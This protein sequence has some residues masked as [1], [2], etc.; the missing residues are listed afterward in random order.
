MCIIRKGKRIELPSAKNTPSILYVLCW[1]LGM[2][3]DLADEA[4]SLF[5]YISDSIDL[6]GVPSIALA[7]KLRFITPEFGSTDTA[8]FVMTT[9]GRVFSFLS[10]LSSGKAHLDYPCRRG[11]SASRKPSPSRL[12]PITTNEIVRPGKIA[13]QGAMTKLLRASVSIRPQSGVG[14]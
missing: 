10:L 9:K 3:T 1:F 11:S 7:K 12:K 4:A 2:S 5:P 6:F 14:G 13:V 8:L